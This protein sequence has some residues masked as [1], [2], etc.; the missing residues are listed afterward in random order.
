MAAQRLPAVQF[1]SQPFRIS[2][3]LIRDT[4]PRK[5]RT[6]A[7]RKGLAALIED[8]LVYGQQRGY[9]AHT[10]T[11]YREAITDFLD[12]FKGADLRTIKP[13]DIRQWIHWLMTQG[14]KRNTISARLYGIRAFFD[15]A[16]FFDIMQS[17]PARL[18]KIHA[19]NK[20]LPKFLSEEEVR[21]FLEAPESLR[22]RTILEVLY[23]TGTRQ[24]EVVGMRIEDISW[25]ERTVRVI[26][27]GDK[28]RLVPL[29]RIAVA[30]LR[31]YIKDRTE[32]PVFLSKEEC[33]ATQR[34][35]LALQRGGGRDSEARANGTTWYAYWRETVNGK[36]KLHGQRIGTIDQFPTRELARQEAAKFLAGKDGVV[37][38]HKFTH[39]SAS[40][41][42][43]LGRD[44]GRIVANAAKKAGLPHVNPHMLR[45]TFATHLLEH[46]ADLLTIRDLLGHSSIMTTQIYASV[47]KS[48]MV[49][50]LQ[51][52]HPRWQENP[53][54]TSD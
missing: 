29:G 43:I 15:R 14:K 2:P 1:P 28:Q 4:A 52:C 48:H 37:G 30:V 11:S 21:K 42:G 25:S 54:E 17:N 33:H 23:A 18:I 47:T 13:M 32:G 27:K 3:F 44:I 41:R 46:G 5:G 45:H 38:R 34:G 9:S 16:V 50:T 26:G 24:A 49:K 12:F 31:N 36:R 35:G 10:L 20:P 51:R 6:S 7:D 8:F 39:S 22:D 53:N 40:G 19:Y